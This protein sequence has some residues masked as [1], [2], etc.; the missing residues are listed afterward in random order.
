MLAAAIVSFGITGCKGKK[1]HPGKE[2]PAQKAPAGENPT[3]A[4]QPPEHP[5]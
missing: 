1:E 4:N 3:D 5:K 2:H